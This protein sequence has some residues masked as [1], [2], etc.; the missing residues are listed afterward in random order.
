MPVA[1]QMVTA[2][3]DCDSHDGYA[4]TWLFVLPPAL[5]MSAHAM[6]GRDRPC[7]PG[8]RPAAGPRCGRADW[9]RGAGQARLRRGIR[10]SRAARR[11]ACPGYSGPPRRAAPRRAA[12]ARAGPGLTLRDWRQESP[13]KSASPCGAGTAA[14]LPAKAK[15]TGRKSSHSYWSEACL[16]ARPAPAMPA[17]VAGGKP[18]PSRCA[19]PHEPLRKGVRPRRPGRSLD[20][21]RAVPGKY[22]V[23]SRGE[24]AVPVAEQELEAACALAEVHEQVPGLL[25]CPGP[26]R[27]SSHAQDMDG[28][29]LDLHHEQDMQALQQHSVHVQKVT[30]QDAGRLNG[31]ELPPRRR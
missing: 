27:M 13:A 31:Q 5:R 7:Q 21:P 4:A 28:P 15:V 1:G 11:A 9:R 29:G 6:P 18:D 22:I 30:R 17:A 26:G 24:L 16:S 12:D 20:H 25:S 19:G 3:R 8:Q 23:E 2:V 10:A 14:Q